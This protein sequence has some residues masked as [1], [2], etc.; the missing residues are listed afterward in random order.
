MPACLRC[1][2]VVDTNVLLYVLRCSIQGRLKAVLLWLRYVDSCGFLWLVCAFVVCPE[3][4][5]SKTTLRGCVPRRSWLAELILEQLWQCL[6]KKST[7]PA[8]TST[9]RLVLP[10]AVR[11]GLR[12]APAC[13]ANMLRSLKQTHARAVMVLLYCGC[14]AAATTTAAA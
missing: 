9:S 14:G 10:S 12:R 11:L 13:V 1:R 8:V 6:S 7:S 3:E 2:T 4:A 5:G